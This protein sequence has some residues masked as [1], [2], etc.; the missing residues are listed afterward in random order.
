MATRGYWGY[1]EVVRAV[2]S[3]VCM[4]LLVHSWFKQRSYAESKWRLVFFTLLLGLPGLGY[5]WLGLNVLRYYAYPMNW[6]MWELWQNV[7]FLQYKVE[8]LAEVLGLLV[9]AWTIVDVVRWMWKRLVGSSR[10][11][12]SKIA[13]GE[14]QRNPGEDA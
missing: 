7:C 2:C 13:Q 1:Y 5:V 14:A 3:F 8:Q 10:R 4:A 12:Q 9:V 11:E 6:N